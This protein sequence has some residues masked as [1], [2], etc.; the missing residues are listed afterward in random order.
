M[1]TTTKK[2]RK[3]SDVNSYAEL[4]GSLLR[5]AR[6]VRGRERALERWA[7]KRAINLWLPYAL[8]D[9]S[10]GAKGSH[11]FMAPLRIERWYRCTLVTC[12][13]PGPGELGDFCFWYLTSRRAVFERAVARA[14]F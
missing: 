13:R 2:N 8:P 5:I 10:E 6:P 1:V 4:Y 12:F 11:K 3:L 9:R 7:R 14:A